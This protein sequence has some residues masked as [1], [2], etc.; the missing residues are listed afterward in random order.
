MHS[1]TV[2]CNAQVVTMDDRM[3]VAEAVRVADGRIEAVG[4]AADLLAGAGPDAERV[5]LR[6]AALLPGWIDSHSHITLAKMFPDFSPPPVGDIDDIGK[7]LRA[8]QLALDAERGQTGW[9]V[10]RGYDNAVFP[11]QAHPT[12]HDLDRL[13]TERPVCMLHASMHMCVLNSKGLALAGITA[14]MPDPAGGVIGRSTDGEPNGILEEAAA[15]QVMAQP[16]FAPGAVALLDKFE[17]AQR[18]YASFGITTAQ[19]GA[20]EEPF[21]PLLRQLG[22]QGRMLLDV[23]AYPMVTGDRKLL[24]G[25]D[26]RQT[27]YRDHFRI[28]GAK[29]ILDGSP[30]AKTAWLTQPYFRPPDGQKED[31]RGYP[32]I[33]D[34]DVVCGYFRLCL[35]HSWQ[36]LVHC[37][38][39]AAADQYLSQY[40]RARRE[41]GILTDL[42]PVMIHAQTLRE[43]QLDRCAALG[44]RPSFFHDHTYYWG[45]HHLTSSLG[46]ARGRRISPLRA[47]LARGLP[48]TLHQ[49]TPIVP[50]D[51][52][53]TLHNA[54][55]RVTRDGRPI[56]PEFAVGVAD[57]LRAVTRN[58]AAQY[59]EEDRKG[60]IEPGKLADLVVLD[61]NPLDTPKNELKDIRVLQTIKQ[62]R[63]IF[64]A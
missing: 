14:G 8:V 36:I 23:C 37:N 21:L 28:A 47:A 58:A 54:V 31:Y 26:S 7:L 61:R 56:G 5:D 49:D 46:P 32:A 6:G 43:D 39:D 51:M 33:A 62:G 19:D 53:F 12:R 57:A 22:R 20:F 45:D 10:G 17:Q 42:R 25:V 64:R 2:Y 1:Q 24:A 52:L 15:M 44:V 63:T 55:N 30:Q 27:E 18:Y 35:Q 11:R 48:F 38:G 9:F 41:T 59:F 13:H 34:D 60:S 29:L 3:S 50:P 16:G 4:G 40:A